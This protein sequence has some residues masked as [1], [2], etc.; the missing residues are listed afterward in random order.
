MTKTSTCRFMNEIY[1]MLKTLTVEQI[2]HMEIEL[3][4]NS[5]PNTPVALYCC[6]ET[7]RRKNDGVWA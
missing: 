7:I 3:A 5:N 2:K 1:E 4:S 6:R